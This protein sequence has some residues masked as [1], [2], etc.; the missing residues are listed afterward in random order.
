MIMSTIYERPVTWQIWIQTLAVGI[1]NFYYSQGVAKV[2]FHM[3]NKDM[4]NVHSHL[5]T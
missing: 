3:Q 4:K 1:Q 5:F 2:D